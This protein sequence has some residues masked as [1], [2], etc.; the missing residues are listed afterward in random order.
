MFI[1]QVKEQLGKM[2]EAEK[3]EWILTQAKLLGES[4][5]QSFLKENPQVYFRGYL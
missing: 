1:K 2:S 4:K 3:E 5:Q